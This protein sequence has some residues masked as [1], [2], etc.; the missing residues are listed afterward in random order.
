VQYDDGAVTLCCNYP[1]TTTH[2]LPI[3]TAGSAAGVTRAVANQL[4]APTPAAQE[5]FAH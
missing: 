1:E 2:E 3:M 4:A 5:K